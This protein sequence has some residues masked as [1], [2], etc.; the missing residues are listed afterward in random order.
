MVLTQQ[1]PLGRFFN[2]LENQ[3]TSL[4]AGFKM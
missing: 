4:L 2:G 3:K 1:A